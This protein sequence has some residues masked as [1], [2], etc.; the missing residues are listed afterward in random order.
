MAMSELTC[1]F[2]QSHSISMLAGE[3][4]NPSSPCYEWDVFEVGVIDWGG[5]REGIS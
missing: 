3:G 4:Y 2:K 5:L 1:A